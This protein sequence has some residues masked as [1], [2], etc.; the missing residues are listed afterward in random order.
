MNTLWKPLKLFLLMTLLTGVVYPLVITIIAQ[1]AKEKANGSILY[2][3]EKAVGSAL[4]AQK[5][6]HNNHF[7]PRPSANDYDAL[8]SGGSN[9]GPT[10]QALQKA[11]N[12]RKTFLARA[13]G[14]S[15]DAVPR[16]LLFTSGSG[17]DPHISLIAVNF[18]LERVL[19]A[20]GLNSSSDRKRVE[21]MIS[22]L[23]QYRLINIPHVNVLLLNKALDES[24]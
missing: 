17:L 3:Q 24:R 16:E 14:V 19:K 22:Q 12:E 1:I 5:F 13:H 2:H 10:S 21:D 8:N 7:W 9:L 6:S 4:I 23:I 18:Q 11:V 15:E 20:R